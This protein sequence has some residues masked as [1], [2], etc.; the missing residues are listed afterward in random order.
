MRALTLAA[1]VIRVE[2][3]SHG[4]RVRVLGVRVHEWH[5]GAAILLGLGATWLA[6]L[7]ADSVPGGLACVGAGWLVVKDWRDLLPSQRD[8]C[9][10]RLG[11]HRRSAPLRE[12]RR[13]EGLPSIAAAVAGAVGVVNL[14]SAVTPNIAWRHHLLLQLEPVAAVPLFHALAVPA[15]VALVVTAWHL[16]L[17]RRRALHAA[18]ALTVALG[19]LSLLKGLDFEEALLSFAAAA[20]LWW[21]REAFCVRHEALR[22]QRALRGFA[23]LAAGAFVAASL[24]VWLLAARGAGP[25]TVAHDTLDLLVWTKG[26]LGFGDELAWIPAALGL[27]GLAAIV[28]GAALLFRPLAPSRDLPAAV[29]REA[30][31]SLVRSHGRDTLA[32]FKLRRDVHYFFSSDRRAFAAYRVESGVLLVAGD[33][34]GADDALPGLVRELVAFAEVRGLRVGV[35]G[36]SDRLLEL[37]SQAGLRALYIGDEAI[38]D[39]ASL[40]LEGRRVRK[41]RQAIARVERAG[42]RAE[43]HELGTLSPERL[44]ELE[45]IASSWLAGGPERGFA[46]AMDSLRGEHQQQSVVVLGLDAGGVCRGFLHFVP[47][48]GRAAASLSFMRRDREAPNGLT[49]FLV[50][51]ALELLGER[52]F[53]EVSLNFAAFRRFLVRPANRVERAIGR[54][55]ALANPFFQIESLYRFNAKFSPR[56][57]PRYLVFESRLALPRVGLAT[58]LVEGQLPRLRS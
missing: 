6:H 37:W 3:H 48:Y 1:D 43:A 17:R 27:L 16:R 33:P 50:A 22:R 44:A 14:I 51:R 58:L 52:G 9:S 53:D 18:V 36:A 2:R 39:A 41:L 29:E 42:F 21:G 49:E 4:P 11:L 34:V 35:V 20:A 7:W 31:F 57:E 25:L 28:G 38:V 45:A 55:L 40:D 5:L 13:A 46:M 10:W 24:A 23:A 15:S 47:A 30:A 54:L 12:I 32:F 19:F 56:W 26:S 8:T